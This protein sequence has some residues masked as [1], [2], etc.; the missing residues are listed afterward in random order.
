VHNA[1][2]LQDSVYRRQLVRLDLI[3]QNKYRRK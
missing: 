1:D 2:W 3:Q